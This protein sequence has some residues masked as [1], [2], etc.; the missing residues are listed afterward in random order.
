MNLTA[1]KKPRAELVTRKDSVP[2]GR[3]R[4]RLAVAGWRRGALALLFTT[5]ATPAIA[6]FEAPGEEAPA[7]QAS[8]FANPAVRAA[9]ELP[10][11][12]PS[13]YLRATLNLIDLG[14]PQLA[15][16]A[17]DQLV[18]LQLDDA[19]KIGLV[20][21]FGAARLLR[22]ARER[23]LGPDAA[24]FANT[25]LTAAAAEAASP[26][27]MATQIKQL[28]D[29]SDAQQRIAVAQLA[30]VGEAAVVPAMRV[31]VDEKATDRQRLGA[32]AALLRLA[33][34]S[35]G[36]LLATLR[37]ENARL[38]GEAAN[39]LASL[40]SPQ[41]VALLALPAATTPGGSAVDQAYAQLAGQPASIDSAQGLL[42]RTLK[43]LDEGVPAFRADDSG[44]VP[45]WV[46]DSK[47]SLP[48]RLSLPSADATL[49]YRA[50]LARD[51]ALL[52]P[53]DRRHE[54]LALRLGIEAAAVLRLAGEEA[55]DRP[56]DLAQ[57]PAATLDDL[58][59]GALRDHQNAAA[60]ASLQVIT[61]RRDPAALA[62][63]DGKPSP[64]ARALRSSHPSVRLAA[65]EAIAAIDSPRPFP[66]ASYVCPAIMQFVTS[67]G[68][69]EV[70]AAAP[71]LDAAAT[72]AGGLSAEGLTGRVA[73]TGGE[74]IRIA[75]S[76]ADIELILLDMAIGSP[77]VREVVFQ[78]RR[79]PGTSQLPIGLLARETQF[80]TARRMAGEHT[81]VMAFL[82]PHTNESLGSLAR[83]LSAHLPRDWPTPEQ[84]LDQAG[85]AMAV[86]HQL[87][88][89]DR[90]FYRLRSAGPAIV[91]AL[92]G[93]QVTSDTASVLALLGTRE[94]QLA[95]V[96]F[97]STLS[98]ALERRR[99]AANAFVQSIERFGLLLT[100]EEILQQYNL[101]NGSES[102]AKESQELLGQLLDAIEA[103]RK[104][105]REK[106]R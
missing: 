48:K 74:A 41:A 85:R 32:R 81:G 98:L 10:R 95:L 16:Q 51:L 73:S 43:N 62:T 17:L 36:A 90:S 9:V 87:L 14:E 23:E 102:Q 35:E 34:F 1:Q 42:T 80:G 55:T 88:E 101:Y 70:V 12:E 11:N 50:R 63:H 30:A 40:R 44:N 39:L 54:S 93:G 26:E 52:R 71:R 56:G 47:T 75:S 66:G 57:L 2:S 53:H 67:N 37:S 20:Q 59:T 33:P 7:P 76:S 91:G 78:L 29:A 13:D 22:L 19:G 83:E 99:A 104:A 49:L 64:T 21:Q 68:Q 45:Y 86:M 24:T 27:R 3:L 92:H 77:A 106:D 89:T 97:S 105:K 61:E 82:R 25:C 103:P 79:N 58:L 96:D 72:W 46:W 5:L 18:A 8:T 28:G 94:S 65:I 60:M 6:Q 100:S 84:R 38:V 4:R 15:K 31:L 69:R